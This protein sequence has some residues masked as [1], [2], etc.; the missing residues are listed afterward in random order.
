[1][2]FYRGPLILAFKPY[3]KT[4][5]QAHEVCWGNQILSIINSLWAAHLSDVKV[6]S[7]EPPLTSQRYF[8]ESTQAGISPVLG[9]ALPTEFSVQSPY[10]TLSPVQSPIAPV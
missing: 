7:R 4:Q 2:S 8:P 9:A 1:M 10:F 6:K 5:W 3:P